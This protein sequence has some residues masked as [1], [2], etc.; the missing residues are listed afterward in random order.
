MNE[1]VHELMTA[2]RRLEDELAHE[3]HAQQVELLYW[4]EGR[5]VRFERSIIAAHRRVKIGVLRWLSASNP[6]NV[7]SAPF[8]YGM[9]VPFALLDLSISIYQAICFR[10]YRIP[11]VR[12]AAY[13]VI[14]RHHLSYLNPVEK[15]NCVYCGYANGVIALTRE[16][17]ARTEQYWCPLKHARKIL[18]PHRRYVHFADFGVSD[19]FHPR[20]REVREALAAEDGET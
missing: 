18:D 14:D 12:R 17:A 13:I 9:I 15:L 8:V 7:L 3:L 6:R 19:T 20:I 4:F 11:R 10:L 5:K 1:R 2:I 16:V